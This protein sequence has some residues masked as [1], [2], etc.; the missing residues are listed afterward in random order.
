MIKSKK[1]TL[2]PLSS[3][4][5]IVEVIIDQTLVK[6]ISSSGAEGF[7]D[8]Q[9]HDTYI[10]FVKGKRLLMVPLSNVSLMEK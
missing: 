5:F 10:S 8:I 4:K 6:G 9:M 1:E 7:T 2:V 3:V